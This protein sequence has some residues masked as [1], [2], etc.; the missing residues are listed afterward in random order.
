MNKYE[1]FE[2][3]STEITVDVSMLVK[4]DDMS[5]NATEIAKSFDKQP[6]DYLR[7]SSTKEY[8]CALSTLFSEK[9]KSP[10]DKTQ[11]VRVKNGGRYK[12]TWM[13]QKLAL[14]FAR[15]LS[16]MFSVKLDLLIIKRLKEEENRKRDR[17]AA[18]T[19]YLELSLAVMNDH[20][21]VQGYHFSN[22][23]NLINRIVLGMDSKRFKEVYG[24]ENIRDSMTEFQIH[25]IRE[26][27]EIDTALMKT[28]TDYQDRKDKLIGYYN[29]KMLL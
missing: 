19:G 5:F 6:K 10:T 25:A 20:E 4:T 27:Q 1:I 23:A 26:L 2:I 12:G 15:W 28:G 22:E 21:E 3:D 7:L 16:P 9:A 24:V 13:H 14:D 8:M 17:L 18:K 29:T 11:F